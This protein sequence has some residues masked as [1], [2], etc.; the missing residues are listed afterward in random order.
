MARH[1]IGLTTRLKMTISAAL[2]LTSLAAC[3]RP[4]NTD[5]LLAEAKQYRQK[6]ESKAAIIQL[7][8]AVQKEPDNAQ[9]RLLLGEMY[10]ESGDTVSAEKELRKAQTLGM[11]PEDIMPRLGKVM[12]M[13][14]QFE[15]LLDEIKA[16]PGTPNQTEFIALRANANLGLGNVEQAKELF[17]LALKKNPD[18]NDALFGLAKIA[19]L[20]QQLSTAAQLIEQALTKNPSDIDCLR[21]KGDLLRMQGQNDA[22]RLVY[23]QILKLR[24]DNTQAHI[25]IANLHIQAGKFAEA[26]T[27][28]NA[29]HKTAP[30]NLLVTY[31]QAVLDFREAKFKSALES[32]QKVLRVEPEHMPSLVLMGSVQLALGSYQQAEQYLQKFLGANPTHLYASKMLASIALKTGKPEA[33]I[34]LLVPLLRANQNDVQLL[35]LAG[36][37]HMQAK[38]FSKAAD[39]FQKASDL[40]PQTASLHTALGLSRL[41]TGENAR[42]IAEL[43]R[44]TGL[45]A[46]GAQAGIMLVMTHLRSKQYDKALAA[47]KAM[48]PQ[49][50]KNPMVHNLK[51]GVF[52][53]RNDMAAARA[54]FQQALALDPV[55]LPALENLAQLDLLEKKPEQARQRLEAALAK[56]KKSAS[57]MTL[58]AKL[59]IVQ[60]NK[61]EAARWLERATTENPDALPPAMLLADFYRRSGEMEKSLVLAR[62]LQA[63]NPAN[64]DTL[65]LLAQVQLTN[66]NYD[67]ALE[68]YTKLAVLQPASAA[69]Q[70]RIANAQ[71]ALNDKAGALVSA[72]KA[73]HLKE[74]LFEAQ[75]LAAALLVEKKDYPEALKIT[76]AVQ[77]QRAGAPDGLR[78]EGDVWMAQN[79]PLDALKLYER[80]FGMSKSGPLLIKI[81]Q[82]LILAGKT[83]DA[84]M[85]I[86]RWLQEH[87]A[88]LTTRLYFASNKLS[89]KEYKLAIEQFEK[90]VQQDPKNVIA[91]NNLAW[92]YQQGKDDRALAFA[93]RAYKLAAT[94]PV[95]LDTLGW[96]LVEKGDP[97]RALPLLQK[98]S[99]LA[100]NATEIR[101]HLGLGL[102][103]SGDKRGARTQFEQLLAS[104]KDFPKRD[105][106]KAMLAQ[107]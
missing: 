83:Q 31:T 12:L 89:N 76:Q 95:I 71:V 2:L 1:T 79:K 46:K 43:E 21:F 92:A 63:S 74:D 105:E 40:A 38:H 17:E 10:I 25:D 99:S 80:A 53:A 11:K 90:I 102:M 100:P 24:P 29:A 27:A 20:S 50:V 54:S 37:A 6:G 106:V 87:P 91:L 98:A 73:L 78:L 34:D 4:Q 48:E 45:G 7:K 103:K 68:S 44:A 56:D 101:Y 81:H 51:G 28:I 86:T 18:L 8:N 13:Q 39:Y 30:N 62:K 69:V 26:K 93:E 66:G 23:T 75:L 85:R 57:L 33:V 36:E 84:N 59:A 16:S 61:A 52:V 77:K 22:A 5:A 96:I 107:L 104:N 32:L 14:G 60:G 47:V 15:K 35:A 94:N 88:D 58:L 97:A 82:S 49:Q 41:G 55:Y 9:A 70:M 67:A 19:V 42:A 72:K 64:P 65:A 3:N